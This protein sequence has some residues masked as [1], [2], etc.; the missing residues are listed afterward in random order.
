[1]LDTQGPE[2]RTGSFSNN[3]KELELQRDQIVTL[4]ND[5]S[6]R[7]QQTKDL[8]W[9]SYPKLTETVVPGIEL[10]T[11]SPHEPHDCP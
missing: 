1:M 11:I 2:I 6:V 9:L 8:I 10:Y 4:T 7:D 5:P 3:V